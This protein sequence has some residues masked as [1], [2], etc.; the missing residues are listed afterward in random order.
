MKVFLISMMLKSE[1]LKD[2]SLKTLNLLMGR[3]EVFET[4]DKK[5]LIEFLDAPV[6]GGQAGAENG[7]LTIM[8]GG[9]ES[10]YSKISNILECWNCF[11]YFK[12]SH[13]INL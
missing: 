12:N 13:E 11:N 1:L 6:S 5:K 9:K 4:N 2:K 7:A 10:T 8:I 3:Q